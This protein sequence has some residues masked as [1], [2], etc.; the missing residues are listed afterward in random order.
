MTLTASG[1]PNL[2]TNHQIRQPSEY[3]ILTGATNMD[4]FEESILELT[5]L[6]SLAQYRDRV[7]R[8]FMAYAGPEYRPD[9]I[10]WLEFYWINR[11]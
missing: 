6:I 8:F 3:I 5:N 4:A 10:D 11:N 9:Y 7:Y 1:Y 2:T